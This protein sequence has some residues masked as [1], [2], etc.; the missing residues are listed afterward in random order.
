MTRACIVSGSDLTCMQLDLCKLQQ[1]LTRVHDHLIGVTRYLI[2]NYLKCPIESAI[3]LVYVKA[4]FRFY[5][6]LGAF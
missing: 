5:I 3:F 1:S 2:V 4:L 6:V